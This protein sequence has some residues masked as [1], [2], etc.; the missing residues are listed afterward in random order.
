M[1]TNFYLHKEQAS[2][3]SKIGYRAKYSVRQVSYELRRAVNHKGE[4]ASDIQE[5]VIRIVIDGFADKVL[6][7]WIFD[8]VI[9][10]TGKISTIDEQHMTI[11]Q[12]YF[13][14]AKIIDYRMN[15]DSRGNDSVSTIINIEAKEIITDKDL[16]YI[17]R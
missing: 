3:K 7:R 9:S 5:G 14:E 15:Y 16:Q 2:E 10:Q 8:R 4:I 12:L 6:L 13:A 11:S 17:K 1:Q